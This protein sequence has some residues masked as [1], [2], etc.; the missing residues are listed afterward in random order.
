[1]GA[2]FV[3]EL[4]VLRPELVSHLVLVGPATDPRRARRRRLALDLARDALREPLSGNVL[5]TA[6]YIRCGPRWYLTE[7]AVMLAYRTD[8]R[9]RQVQVPTLVIRGADD[10]IARERWCGELSDAA[11]LGSLV[12]IPGHRHL[13]QHS[14]PERTAEA[15][16][17][18]VRR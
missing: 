18:H 15:V 2:Q 8:A 5:T 7:L 1:M 3:T 14:A 12:Q 10:P 13:V 6:D 16:L 11:T 4:A 9:V 17:R